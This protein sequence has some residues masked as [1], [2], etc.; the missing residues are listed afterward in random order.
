[1][2]LKGLENANHIF[3][4]LFFPSINHNNNE[5]CFSIDAYGLADILEHEIPR[6]H[7]VF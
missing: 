7:N 2:Q 6:C 1:M 5:K 4:S 3:L